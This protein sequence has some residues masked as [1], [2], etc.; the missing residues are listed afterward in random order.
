M[1]VQTELTKK[2]S[3]A[4]DILSDDKTSYLLFG[5]GAG[6][7]KSWLG[8][9]WLTAM[10]F[11]YPGSKWFVGRKELKRLMASTYITFLKVF[12]ELK[13]PADSYRLDGKY[14][15][16]EFT[17]G[18][19]AGS[20]IDLLDLAH[21][22][23]DPMYE[24]FG[25]LEYTGGWIEEAGEIEYICFDI[26]KTRVGR[27]RNTEFGLLPA[28]I[29]L[30]CNPTQNWLYRT[31]YKPFKSE[32][33]YPDSQFIQSLYKDNPY[34]ASDYGH[35]L[36]QVTDSILRARLRDGLWE[37]TADNLTLIKYDS[38][39]EM[40]VNKVELDPNRYLSADIARFGA[41]KIVYGIWQGYDLV[42][43]IEKSKQ[44]QTITEQ[45]IRDLMGK[46]NIPYNRC[47]I[48]EDGMGGGIVDHLYGVQGFMGGRSAIPNP[49]TDIKG[50]YKNLRSQCYFMLADKITKHEL[51]VSANLSE[52]Q[53]E[54][55]INDLQQIKRVDLAADAPLQVVP[56]E[57]IK[58]SLGR[59]PDYSDMMMMRMYL[60]LTKPVAQYNPPNKEQ[61][62]KAGGLGEFGGVEGYGF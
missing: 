12:R 39:M 26:L 59:S 52:T 62:M 8:A 21:Q 43:V 48:D 9:L 51:A 31:F 41:D 23:T 56:K 42:E 1:I 27:F 15:Y 17:S 45:E 24:R 37:Y 30:T 6:G 3:D 29:L 60:E 53:R 18:R 4:W 50:N 33:Q 38:I 40:F 13:I 47:V 58:E 34:T 16:I 10:C 14:N 7:G 32:K 54:Q 2:Q 19:A 44:A 61:I 46:N 57:E 22:P 5:G 36:D 28:K 25:S 20:R 35:Q 11:E 55:L 49:T